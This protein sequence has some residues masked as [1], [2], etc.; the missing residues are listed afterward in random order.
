M[1]KVFV[2][3]CEREDVKIRK[4]VGSML[5]MMGGLCC[6][7]EEGDLVL[8]KPNFVAPFPE[9]T[10]NLILLSEVVDQVRRC[11]GTPI[12]GES[13]GFEFNTRNTFEILGLRQFSIDNDVRII[14]FDEG[15]F[16]KVKADGFPLKVP[17][18][19][20]ECD[21]LINIPK[22]KMHSVTTVSLA[23]KNLIGAVHRDTRRRIHISDLSKGIVLI[24]KKIHPDISIVDGLGFMSGRAVFGETKDINYIIAGR[25]S[26]AVDTICCGMMGIDPGRIQHISIARKELGYTGDIQA[27]GD[28]SPGCVANLGG[29]STIRHKVHNLL[30]WGLYASDLAYSKIANR[31][32][33]PSLHW[34]FG[35]RPIID[36]RKCTLCGE[37]AKICPANAIVLVNDIRI[38]RHICQELRCLKCIYSCPEKAITTT[39]GCI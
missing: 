39:K 15:E 11:G 14:N 24:N 4:A 28:Y 37:C 23:L 26:T 17:K 7:V 38:N 32:L 3:K 35:V 27:L 22:L 21:K 19:F 6:I 33:I 5:A 25:N 8:I 36:R 9:A 18:V 34:F 30:F 31:S 13:A 1:E 2:V 10:T 20:F 16:C 29:K 12:I